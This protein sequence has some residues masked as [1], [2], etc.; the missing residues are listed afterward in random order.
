MT[1]RALAHIEKRAIGQGEFDSP[2][3]EAM[4]LGGSTGLQREMKLSERVAEL[5]CEVKTLRQRLVRQAVDSRTLDDRMPWPA[6]Y[7]SV[8]PPLCRSALGKVS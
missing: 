2:G 7:A 8:N 1:L 5:E 6:D 4:L 3:R